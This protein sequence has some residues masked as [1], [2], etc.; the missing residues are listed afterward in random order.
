MMGNNSRLVKKSDENCKNSLSALDA[1]LYGI[2]GGLLL[3]GVLFLCFI[4]FGHAI[5]GQFGPKN[6]PSASSNTRADK[7]DPLGKKHKRGPPPSLDLRPVDVRQMVFQEDAPD[8][9]K[10]MALAG[11]LL[12]IKTTNSRDTPMS[13]IVSKIVSKLNS[14]PIK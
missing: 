6:Q 12:N 14:S 11:K 13:K 2:P 9:V 10:A 5:T 4:L 8:D 3:A 7:K 1:F